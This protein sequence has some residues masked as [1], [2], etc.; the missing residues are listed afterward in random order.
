MG[1]YELDREN[2]FHYTGCGWITTKKP[3]TTSQ[4]KKLKEGKL[5]VINLHWE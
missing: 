4:I 3:L 1:I 2:Y 5:D